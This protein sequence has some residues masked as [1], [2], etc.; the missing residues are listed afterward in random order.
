MKTLCK[1]NDELLPSSLSMYAMTHFGS[2]Q[3]GFN[4]DELKSFRP[5]FPTEDGSEK[6]NKNFIVEVS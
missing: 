4:E 2:Y 3:N 6:Q 5:Q 1:F